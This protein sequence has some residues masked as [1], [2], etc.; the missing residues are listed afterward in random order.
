[1]YLETVDSVDLEPELQQFTMDA[2]RAPQG[3]LL[4]HPPDEIT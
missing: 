2:R 4:A 1:M 3:V